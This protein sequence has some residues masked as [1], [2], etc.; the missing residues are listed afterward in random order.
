MACQGPGVLRGSEERELGKLALQQARWKACAECKVAMRDSQAFRNDEQVFKRVSRS[1]QP[2]DAE[3]WHFMLGRG[4][5]AWSPFASEVLKSTVLLEVGP[6]WTS[7]RARGGCRQL[8]VRLKPATAGE[9]E[10]AE[11]E[12]EAIQHQ[13][14][15]RL[16]PGSLS[17]QAQ[18]VEPDGF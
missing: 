5:R 17:G 4:N 10:K 18:S 16:S 14:P 9:R 6:T 3:F 8:S 2:S 12:E 15:P 13:L 7:L 11:E 1:A